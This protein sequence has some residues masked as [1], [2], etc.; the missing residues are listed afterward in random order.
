MYPRTRTGMALALLFWLPL[1]LALAAGPLDG[2]FEIHSAFIVAE[3]GVLKLS[4]H[5]QYPLTDP[6]RA[7]LHD[8]V[9][10]A[11]DLDLNISR[12]R[13]LWL[14]ASEL[15]MTLRRD[16]SYHAVTDRYVVRNESGAEQQTFPTL[17]DAL[18]QLGR[19]EELPVLIQSQLHG[20]GPWLVSVRAG[21]RRGRMPDALRALMFWS[22]DWHRTSDWYTWT[23][24]F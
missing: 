5:V 16:L 4:A 22:D 24:Q 3:Q 14:N 10:V 7:A 17:E 1:S 13:R 23:L 2:A 9:T 18:D 20:D 19:I 21:V 8:G 12:H 11:F 15:D 6:I